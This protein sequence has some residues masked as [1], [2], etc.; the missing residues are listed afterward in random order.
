MPKKNIGVV[1]RITF[2][3]S[4]KRYI[5]YINIEDYQ[6]LKLTDDQIN[7]V[8]QEL[9]ELEN[10]MDAINNEIDELSVDDLG[11]EE[12]DRLDDEL[13]QRLAQLANE[14]QLFILHYEDEYGLDFDV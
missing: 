11:Q 7:D 10:A 3:A 14:R 6:M 4:K 5:I 8:W 13:C 9:E 12:F 1:I 2:E